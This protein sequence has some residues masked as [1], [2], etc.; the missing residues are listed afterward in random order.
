MVASV[1]NGRRLILRN[2]VYS[3][4]PCHDLYKLNRLRGLL[5]KEVCP[6]KIAVA[7]LG[8]AIAA[9][10]IMLVSFGEWRTPRP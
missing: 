1:N 6:M 7:K 2:V 4:K 10:A 9:R 3:Q 8:I 5:A